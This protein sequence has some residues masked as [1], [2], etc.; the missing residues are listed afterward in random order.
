MSIY[1]KDLITVIVTTYNPK[2]EYLEVCLKSITLQTY[3]KI[4]IILVDDNSQNFLEI[5]NLVK[6]KFIDFKI[7]I[8]KNKINSGVAF[9]LNKAIKY[10]KGKYINW[11]SYDDYF[12]KAKIM[13]QYKIINK[14]KNTIISSDFLIKYENYNF[15]RYS[16]SNSISKKF[17]FL[18]SDIYSGGTFLIPRNILNKNNLF[19]INLRHVQDY[20]LWLR[21]LRN[22]KFQNINE[23]LFVSRYHQNQHSVLDKDSAFIE[24][25]KFYNYY[26]EQN[27][28][29]LVYYLNT[30]KIFFLIFSLISRG[31]F[32]ASEILINSYIK[33]KKINYFKI[34]F[35]KLFYSFVFIFALIHKNI[36]SFIK[37]FIFNLILIFK[38]KSIN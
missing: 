19:D 10:S 21:L 12:Y 5:I 15:Y 37:N 30:P 33:Y 34:I 8:L 2:L 22:I 4:E 28:Y 20:D 11:C 9:S 13:K 6:S 31:F 14:T 1:L 27:F 3:K 36:K 32:Q 35:I 16:K 25:N 24:K 26:V 23:P 7:K 17:S 38:F 29:N 18:F